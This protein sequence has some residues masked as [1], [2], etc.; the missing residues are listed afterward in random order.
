MIVHN[1]YS[2]TKPNCSNF[3]SALNDPKRAVKQNNQT[4]SNFFYISKSIRNIKDTTYFYLLLNYLF[5]IEK[6]LYKQ[7]KLIY[8]DGMFSPSHTKENTT[9]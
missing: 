8:I 4:I 6:T 7:D 3:N 5:F 1:N 9:E 2:Y